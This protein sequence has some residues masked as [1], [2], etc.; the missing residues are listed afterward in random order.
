MSKKGF[1]VTIFMILLAN[2]IYANVEDF[3]EIKGS[4]EMFE[5][6]KHGGFV[7]Y[8]RHGKTD[9]S[10]RDYYPVV[11]NDCSKQRSLSDEGREELAKIGEYIR[12]AN[13]PIG[14]I[15]S[16]PMCRAKEST[17]IMFGE[18][19]T[20]E[21][22]LI[23]TAQLTSEEKKPVIA[24]TRELI[25]TPIKEK[26]VN[27]VMVAHAPNL[28]DLMGYFPETEGSFIVFEPLGEGKYRYLGT[29]L[30]DDW[31]DFGLEIFQ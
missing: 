25:S 31:K 8:I 9:T 30:P 27:R 29:I 11:L 19:Y 16:S 5:K 23:Y 10:Q 26:G 13:I 1:M 12:K 15:F 14:D 4:K 28:A 18:K 24:K 6:L 20:T 21:M 17:L 2:L 7:I 3:E 22:N